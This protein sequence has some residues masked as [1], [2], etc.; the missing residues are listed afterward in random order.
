MIK[1][2]RGKL[3]GISVTDA[4]LDYQGSI[5]LDPEHCAAV[6]LYPLEFVDIWNRT[7]G[8]RFSTYIILGAPGS[9]CCVLNGAAARLCQIG[10]ILIVAASELTTPAEL[11]RLKP[12]ILTFRPGNHIDQIRH[13]DVSGSARP[14]YD[15]YIV[16]GAPPESDEEIEN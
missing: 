12:R 7:N 10:D 13:Y 5:T 3:H 4:N 11:Y 1:V 8:A 6:G 2:L 9:R 14:P 16:D 15:F